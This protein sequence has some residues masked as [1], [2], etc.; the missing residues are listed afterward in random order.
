MTVTSRQVWSSSL[1]CMHLL[2]ESINKRG[3]FWIQQWLGKDCLCFMV[4]LGVRSVFTLV[5]ASSLFLFNQGIFVNQAFP[6]VLVLEGWQ[7]KWTETQVEGKACAPQPSHPSVMWHAHIN[8]FIRGIN[9]KFL[10]PGGFVQKIEVSQ[11]VFRKRKHGI[12]ISSPA[13]FNHQKFKAN[14]KILFASRGMPGGVCCWV[15]GFMYC[16]EPLLLHSL[17]WASRAW[18]SPGNIRPGD[19]GPAQA[20]RTEF[21]PVGLLVLRGCHL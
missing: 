20:G 16:Q 3:V 1:V 2:L 19:W 21:L 18:N 14:V 13:T 12:A 5:W 9:W 6:P 11:W 8:W 10:P 7:T 15:A 4:E 17:G